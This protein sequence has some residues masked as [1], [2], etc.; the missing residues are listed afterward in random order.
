[1]AKHERGY[2]VG[3]Q[4][5]VG[6]HGPR[7]DARPEI[8]PERV[9]VGSA[10]KTSAHP[11][12]R[13]IHPVQCRGPLAAVRIHTALLSVGLAACRRS[14]RCFWSM[15]RFGRCT[16]RGRSGAASPSAARTAVAKNAGVMPS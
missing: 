1:M 14:R 5:L 6:E 4:F 2:A 9:D 16:A 13:D 8:A 12:N 3:L 10:R 7:F 15:A 11:D